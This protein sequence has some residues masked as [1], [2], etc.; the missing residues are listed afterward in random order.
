MGDWL[1]Q[2]NSSDESACTENFAVAR[3]YGIPLEKGVPALA[4]LEP[5]GR[6]VYSQ[7]TGEFE[8]MRH[9]SPESVHEFLL[10]WQAK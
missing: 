3:R 8:D 10:K 6:V 2:D 5:N 7:K 1:T 9:M 4:V